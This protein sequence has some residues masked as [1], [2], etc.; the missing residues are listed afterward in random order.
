MNYQEGEIV[1][2]IPTKEVLVYDEPVTDYK[3][4]KQAIEGID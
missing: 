2:Q 4:F 3:S 1:I